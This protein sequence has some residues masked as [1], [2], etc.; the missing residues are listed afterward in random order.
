MNVDLVGD[1]LNDDLI[2]VYYSD[3]Y[4]EEE[5]DEYDYYDDEDDYYDEDDYSKSNI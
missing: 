1:W 2:D 4:D 3:Y 5:G